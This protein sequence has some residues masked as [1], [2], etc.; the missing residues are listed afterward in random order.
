[1]I[2]LIVILF[3]TGVVAGYLAR[4]WLDGFR[5]GVESRPDRDTINRFGRA[6]RAIRDL[7]RDR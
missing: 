1:V 7:P 5:A 2:A 4:P 6:R 3:G